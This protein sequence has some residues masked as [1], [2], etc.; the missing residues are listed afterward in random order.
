MVSKLYEYVFAAVGTGV[1]VHTPSFG[2][3]PPSSQKYVST[4][5][6]PSAS[7]AQAVASKFALN[8]TSFTPLLFFL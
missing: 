8:V 7:A 2:G 3:P 1:G 5:S 6:L 4:F